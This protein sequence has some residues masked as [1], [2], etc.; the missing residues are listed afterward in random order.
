[1]NE[2]FTEEFTVYQGYKIQKKKKIIKG[3]DLNEEYQK[4]LDE[5][6]KTKKINKETINVRV[7]KGTWSYENKTVEVKK[8]ASRAELLDIRAKMEKD[9][10][11]W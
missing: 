10:F 11:C 7:K 5:I 4:K 3:E 6:H 2:P 1:M 8:N 9:K